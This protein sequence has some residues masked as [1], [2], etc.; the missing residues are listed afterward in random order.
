[1]HQFYTSCFYILAQLQLI[2]LC[3]FQTTIINKCMYET[4]YQQLNYTYNQAWCDTERAVSQHQ[5]KADY[6][7]GSYFTAYIVVR[8]FPN[9]NEYHSIPQATFDQQV[10]IDV[11]IL[12]P[13][14]TIVLSKRFEFQFLFQP[15]LQN[16]FR[17]IFSFRKAI[18]FQF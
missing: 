18:Q 11:L 7:T 6:T 3:T 17:F 8:H 10:S 9:Y 15:S 5:S 14:I 2:V 4:V 13:D 1:M 16:P 12:H